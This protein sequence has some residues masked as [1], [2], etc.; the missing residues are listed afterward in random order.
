MTTK[1]YLKQWTKQ[2]LKGTKDIIKLVPEYL[3]MYSKGLKICNKTPYVNITNDISYYYEVNKLPN[4]FKG[5]IVMP[6]YRI[7]KAVLYY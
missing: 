7:G 2:E 4:D 3:L 5:K 6:K 1:D